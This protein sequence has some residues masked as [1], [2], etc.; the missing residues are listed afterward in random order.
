MFLSLKCHWRRTRTLKPIIHHNISDS[1][2][3][4]T[5]SAQSSGPENIGPERPLP[6]L[7]AAGPVLSPSRITLENNEKIRPRPDGEN[8]FAKASGGE[9]GIRTLGGVA[10]TTVFETA[11]FDHSGTSPRSGGDLNGDA[12]CR[13]GILPQ[14]R[15]SD[16]SEGVGRHSLPDEGHGRRGMTVL[17]AG[18]PGILTGMTLGLSRVSLLRGSP[19]A[20]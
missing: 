12:G 10:P 5:K 8:A 19:G 18:I 16:S 20:L 13:K 14:V 7:L 9:T 15:V 2:N 1:Y 6:G 3:A 11:P 4:F 17:F